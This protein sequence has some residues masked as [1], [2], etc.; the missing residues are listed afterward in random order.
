MCD[1]EALRNL[2]A[3]ICYKLYKNRQQLR[4]LFLDLKGGKHLVQ[5]I[6][7]STENEETLKILFEYLI[8]LLEDEDGTIYMENI[9]RLNEAQAKDIIRDINTSNMSPET[10]EIMD[11]VISL[12]SIE[13]TDE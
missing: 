7:W 11:H 13:D 6:F 3:G 5:Q 8:E 2:T 10:I 9:K 1:K 4:K 12:L